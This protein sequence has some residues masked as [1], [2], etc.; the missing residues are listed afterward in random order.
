[1]ASSQ[2]PVLFAAVVMPIPGDRNIGD[3]WNVGAMARAAAL[4]VSLGVEVFPRIQG[5]TNEI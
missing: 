1:M 3:A 4:G 2:K 5:V